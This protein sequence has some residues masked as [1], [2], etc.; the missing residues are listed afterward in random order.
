[1]TDTYR[2]VADGAV[3]AGAV[4]A[5]SLFVRWD[6]PGLFAFPVQLTAAVAGSAFALRLMDVV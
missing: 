3:V 4:L 2:L 5:L 1:M 6:L